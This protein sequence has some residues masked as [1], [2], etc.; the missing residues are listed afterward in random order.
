MVKTEFFSYL[1]QREVWTSK[2]CSSP[3]PQRRF[4]YSSDHIDGE[5]RYRS[6]KRIEDTDSYPVPPKSTLDFGFDDRD[7]RTL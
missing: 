5:P 3:H 4:L 6:H 2:L 7:V 1:I